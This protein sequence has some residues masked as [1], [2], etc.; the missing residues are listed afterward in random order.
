MLLEVF[1]LLMGSTQ[2]ELA[3][4]IELP[5]QRMH[6]VV[7]GQRGLTPRTALR[8]AKFFGMTPVGAHYHSKL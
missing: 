4:A 7:N 6:D 3:D 2:R 5:S 8:L 1:L